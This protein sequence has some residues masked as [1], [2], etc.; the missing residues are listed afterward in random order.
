ML[1]FIGTTARVLRSIRRRDDG[2][3]AVE[4]ALVAPVFL[5]LLFAIL[6]TSLMF[7]VATVMQGEVAI[8]TRIIRTGQLQNDDDALGTF[9]ETLCANLNNVLTC[10]NVIID[11]RTFDD[12]GE[13]AFEQFVD[14]E[15]G[16]S[17]NEFDPG[18]ADEIVL[19]RI[20]YLYNIVTPYLDEFL[21]TDANGNLLLYAATA[22]KNEPFQNAL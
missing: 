13:M 19:V 7:V 6:E 8:A 17:G 21:P 2:A 18:S 11:V 16:A 22:F 12:F 14:D 1:G 3:T 20:A 9:T 4:I 10:D 5:F 15:G